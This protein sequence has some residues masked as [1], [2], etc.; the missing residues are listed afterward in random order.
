VG[1]GIL[2]PRVTFPPKSVAESQQYLPKLPP[3]SAGKSR[4]GTNFVQIHSTQLERHTVRAVAS[5][6]DFVNCAFQPRLSI[7]ACLLVKSCDRLC[8]GVPPRM[9]RA[10]TPSSSC[11][12]M[13]IDARTKFKILASCVPLRSG[14]KRCGA[15]N[16]TGCSTVGT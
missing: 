14:T 6:R 3:G 8:D 7:Y 1:H 12:H 13:S 15:Q 5:T 4:R 11:H 16:G 2:L 9:G 10:A